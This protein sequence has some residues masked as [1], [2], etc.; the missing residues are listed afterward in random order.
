MLAEMKARHHY[1]PTVKKESEGTANVREGI[2]F[3]DLTVEKIG[4]L[5]VQEILEE[6]RESEGR[7]SDAKFLLRAP[8]AYTAVFMVLSPSFLKSRQDL[9]EWS[10]LLMQSWNIAALYM[11]SNALVTCFACGVVN[12][13]IIN[14]DYLFIGIFRFFLQFF[15]VSSDNQLN[16]FPSLE[17]TPVL[18]S[19][20]IYPCH[21]IIPFSMYDIDSLNMESTSRLELLLGGKAPST[22]VQ[23]AR[24]PISLMDCIHSILRQLEPEK[25]ATLLAHV[26]VTGKSVDLDYSELTLKLKELLQEQVLCKSEYPSDFQQRAS[27]VQLLKV[28]EYFNSRLQPINASESSSA[29][30]ETPPPIN[31]INPNTNNNN[32]NVSLSFKGSPLLTQFSA[33]FGS[34]LLSKLVFADPKCFLTRKEYNDFGPRHFWAKQLFN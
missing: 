19:N 13:F 2:N 5:I 29:S 9:E 26:I 3:L 27:G 34:C 14:I 7:S 24:E 12:G 28:P 22:D 16:Y 21:M 4:Q 33:F 23:H 11:S 8:L 18:D 20:V 1:F 31:G 10:K 15:W 6:P 30:T 32:N 25:Q 17:I